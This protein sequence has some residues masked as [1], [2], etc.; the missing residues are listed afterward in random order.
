MDQRPAVQQLDCSSSRVGNQWS[1]VPTHRNC[2]R[3]PRPYQ[4]AAGKDSVLESRGQLGRTARADGL[5]NRC[6]QRP[7]MRY[8]RPCRSRRNCCL[9]LNS[10]IYY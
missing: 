2:Q 7:V 4:C 10:V 3:E 1:I 5:G 8:S 6:L 9:S